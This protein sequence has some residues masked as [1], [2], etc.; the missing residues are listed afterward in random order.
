MSSQSTPSIPEPQ[1][2]SPAPGSASPILDSG[3]HQVEGWITASP[4]KFVEVLEHVFTFPRLLV[5]HRDLISTSVRRELSARFSGTLLGWAWPLV[6]PLLMFAIYYFI[7][8]KLLSVKFG[9]LPEDQQSAMGVFMFV[10]I[11]IWTAFGESVVRC[12]S[13]IVDNG[14]LIK[15]V[16]FPTEVLPLN[17]ILV[18]MVTMAFG[19]LAFIAVTWLTPFFGLHIWTPPDTARLVWILVLVPLQVFFTYGIGLLLGTLQVYLRDT[20]QVVTVGITVWMFATPIFWTPELIINEA[21]DRGLPEEWAWVIDVNPMHHLVYAWR[22]ILMSREPSMIFHG[23]VQDSVLTFG[24][25]AAGSFV[26]GYT[27]FLLARRRFA[28]EV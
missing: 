18:A 22:D 10:G 20:Q 17:Q 8:T 1:G 14:N 12:T 11:L 15:K 5:R 16:A 19:V 6:T 2:E 9:A 26:V 3:S 24:L 27:F 13:V 4:P 25:W 21:G 7:F 23:P 28:D